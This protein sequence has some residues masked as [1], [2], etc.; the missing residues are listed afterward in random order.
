M[1][2]FRRYFTALSFNLFAVSLRNLKRKPIRTAILILSIGLL[3]SVLVFGGSFIISV[4]STVKKAADRLGADLLVVPVGARETAQEVLLE[5]KAATFFMHKSILD[6]VREMEG[7]EAATYHTYLSSILGVCCDVPEAKIVAFDQDTDFILGPWLQKKLGRRLEKREAIIGWAAEDN[8]MLLEVDS[9]VLFNLKFDFVGVLEK[10]GTGLDDAIFVSDENVPDMARASKLYAGEDE[11]SVI[12]AKLKPGYTSEDVGNEVENQIVDADV[13][14][15]AD[16]G[17]RIIGILADINKL[18]LVIVI[19]TSLI[20]TFLAWS[21]FSAIANERMKEI[22]IMRAIGAKCS[23]VLRMFIAEVIVVSLLGS[24]LGI[25][26]GNYM[27][28][29]LNKSLTL[30]MEL[31]TSLSL[32]E[33]AAVSG[34]GFIVG[35]AICIAGAYSSILRIRKLDPLSA[36]K[37][38]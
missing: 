10:T 7:V 36:L 1:H 11:I 13:I 29:A 20:S 32:G 2:L 30:L 37:E 27:S 9:S 4:S 12:F 24:T 34:L 35:F 31:S 18:F 14:N 16:I 23:H 3:V 33:R 22:S 5:T 15:R 6:R 17:D 21:V 26:G 8:L 28:V 38:I 25:L 19:L